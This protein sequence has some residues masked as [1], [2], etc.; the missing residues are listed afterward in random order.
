MRRFVSVG[1]YFPLLGASSKAP[2]VSD[3]IPIRAKSDSYL[4]EGRLTPA[5]SACC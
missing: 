4:A 3:S 5:M 1:L 2:I